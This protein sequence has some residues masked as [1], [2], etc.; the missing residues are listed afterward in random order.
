MS[1][2]YQRASYI[3]TDIMTNHDKDSSIRCIKLLNI[4]ACLAVH[5]HVKHIEFNYGRVS[6]KATAD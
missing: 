3:P 2:S 6:V 4:R 5:C 1:R